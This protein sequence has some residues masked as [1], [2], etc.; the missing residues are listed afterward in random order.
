[1]HSGNILEDIDIKKS[2]N[3]VESLTGPLP[4]KRGAR[5]IVTEFWYRPGRWK[6]YF[7]APAMPVNP[8]G[9]PP[10]TLSQAGDAAT[11][12]TPDAALQRNDATATGQES[13]IPEDVRRLQA[14]MGAPVTREPPNPVDMVGVPAVGTV[15]FFLLLSSGTVTNDFLENLMIF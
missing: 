9:D 12:K 15:T 13:W 10:E 2:G 7:D 11:N 14:A 4:G 1:M 5:D 8:I 6:P 3:T